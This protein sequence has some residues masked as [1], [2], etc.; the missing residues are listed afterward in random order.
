MFTKTLFPDTLRA[1]KI[2]AT[3]PTVQRAYLAGETA[4]ALQLGH[5][6]SVD[7]DF[8]TQEKFDENLVATEL[9]QISSFK[10]DQRAWATVLGRIGKTRFSIFHYKYRILDPLLQFEGIKLVGKRDIATMKIHAISDRG[11]KR[12]FIDVYLLARE[13][14]LAQMLDCYNEKYGSLDSKSYQLIKGLS[15]FADAEDDEMPRMLIPVKWDE[16]KD[17]FQKETRRL[18]SEKLHI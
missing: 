8:F 4:L 14:T 17:F 9:S 1:I 6:M 15:Y 16:V 10:E 3:I 2:T 13:F 12:D 7:L 11:V 18:A 5:R